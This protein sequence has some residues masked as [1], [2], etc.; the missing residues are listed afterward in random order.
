MRGLEEGLGE[1]EEER[2]L[3]GRVG[4][5]GGGVVIGVAGMSGLGMLLGLLL[6]FLF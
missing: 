2:M 4:D 5:G 3:E 1:G 6:V